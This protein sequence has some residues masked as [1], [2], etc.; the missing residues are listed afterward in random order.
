MH[1]ADVKYF[2]IVFRQTK[3]R[4]RK[5]N[6]RNIKCHLFLFFNKQQKVYISG[7]LVCYTNKLLSEIFRGRQYFSRN[8][9]KTHTQCSER[10]HFWSLLCECIELHK[11][12]SGFSGNNCVCSLAAVA[13][14]LS[15]L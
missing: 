13:F 10:V 8:K 15:A 14:I 4:Q 2:N 7:F 1:T 3:Q 6:K 12:C 11:L 5:H 9:K